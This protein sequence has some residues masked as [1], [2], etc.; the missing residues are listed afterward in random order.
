[1]NRLTQMPSHIYFLLG[2]AAAGLGCSSAPPDTLPFGNSGG[3][4]SSSLGGSSSTSGGSGGSTATGAGGTTI[5]IGT[6]GSTAGDGGVEKCA[7]V[8][9][10][11]M[12]LPP[13]L[14]FLIDT[15]GSMSSAPGGMPGAPPP[16]G[17]PSKWV[18]TRDALILAFNDMALGTG[19]GLIY[20][21]NVQTSFGGPPMGRGGDCRGAC[22][23][24]NSGRDLR[25]ACAEA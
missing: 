16:A 7:N 22:R 21:P 15:S 11:A 24:S 10:T 9:S 8:T 23:H 14:G 3:T 18:S 20:Y 2:V 25:G 17:T 6:A 12:P 13:V 1:M 5:P 4:K 19:T